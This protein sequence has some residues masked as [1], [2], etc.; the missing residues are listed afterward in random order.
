[1]AFVLTETYLIVRMG[2][3]NGG[4]QREAICD[5][6]TEMGFHIGLLRLQA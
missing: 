3:H 4:N 6:C 2:M 5:I 1:M